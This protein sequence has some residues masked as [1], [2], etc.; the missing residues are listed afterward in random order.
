MKNTWVYHLVTTV[1]FI[2][3]FYPWL[4]K[5]ISTAVFIVLYLVYS[6]VYFPI[7]DYHRLV[8]LGKIQPGDYKEILNFGTVKYRFKYYGALMFGKE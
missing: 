4:E 3:I 1:L 7:V 2:A 6:F 8:A 5:E